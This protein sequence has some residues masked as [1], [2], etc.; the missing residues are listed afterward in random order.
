MI[1]GCAGGR[2]GRLYL[3]ALSGSRKGMKMENKVKGKAT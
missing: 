3:R 1:P 2:H